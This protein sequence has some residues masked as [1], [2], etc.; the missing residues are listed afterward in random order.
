ML[1]CAIEILNITIIIIIFLLCLSDNV[2]QVVIFLL[3]VIDGASSGE[4]KVVV[5][6]SSFLPTTVESVRSEN[7][8]CRREVWYFVFV[9]IF[10]L[11]LWAISRLRRN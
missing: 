8:F 1:I 9:L 11:T 2:R 6:F 5:W 4:W 3:Y 10:V 7:E